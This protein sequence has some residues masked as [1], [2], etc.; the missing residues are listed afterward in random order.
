MSLFKK[1]SM[2]AAAIIIGATASASAQSEYPS[3]PIS[4]TAPFSPGGAADTVA[5]IVA[6][7]LS[8]SLGQ[9][10]VVENKAGAGGSIGS[11]AV[12]NT[13]PDGY[14]LLLNL[15]P[16][17]QTVHIFNKE[18]QYDP[19]NDFT[20]ISFVAKAPQVLVVP[21]SSPYNTAA[22][23][24]K[25]AI[26]EEKTYGSSGIGTSQHLAGLML[27]Q[28]EGAKLLHIAYKSGSE[29]LAGV[30]GEQ[31][32]AA[33]VVLSNVV[34]YIESGELKALGVVENSRALNAPDIPTVGEALG[35]DFSVPETWV[36]ILAPAGL[37]AAVTE[38]LS[39]EINAA[40]NSD[41]VKEKLQK[42]GY[43]PMTASPEAFAK[44]LKESEAMYRGI[45]EAAGLIKN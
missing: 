34:P 10:V 19:V 42:A 17:H 1:V 30:L 39:K 33:I 28:S 15:G 23:F 36:G 3:K 2:F 18:V 22:E 24:I 45:V 27:S 11:N 7:P 4:L 32:D 44:Q 20:A 43:E 6:T 9:P 37:P 29:A 5:R 41:A 8:E 26:E 16:P 25:A 40:V 13:Q 38:K 12:A 35:N 14:S 31:T 21:G